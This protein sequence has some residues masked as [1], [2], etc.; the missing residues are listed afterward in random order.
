MPRAPR[1]MKKP[2][3]EAKS[4]AFVAGAKTGASG[5]AKSA[6]LG[7]LGIQDLPAPAEPV[8]VEEPVS[9][10]APEV[11]PEAEVEVEQ[12]PEEVLATDVSE[13][14]EAPEPDAEVSPKTAA[15]RKAREDLDLKLQ[16]RG[17]D[18]PSHS[19]EPELSR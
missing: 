17:L 19:A 6:A 13:P 4:S 3:P 8:S 16:V 15:Y 14:H 18:G 10:A 11:E 7:A 2:G 5:V 9:H 12:P 1:G